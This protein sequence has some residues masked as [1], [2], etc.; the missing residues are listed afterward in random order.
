MVLFIYETPL[1]TTVPNFLNDTHLTGNDYPKWPWRAANALLSSTC[2]L[3]RRGEEENA[4]ENEAK[5]DVGLTKYHEKL[6][7]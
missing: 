5:R 7:T 6:R 1:S 2:L 3:R 4:R